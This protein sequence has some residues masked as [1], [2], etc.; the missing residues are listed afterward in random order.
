MKPFTEYMLSLQSW[1]RA[2]VR[3]ASSRWIVGP[4]LV[5]PLLFWNRLD[6]GDDDGGRENR[7]D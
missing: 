4:L 3:V 5:L 1:W 6:E 2:A 7:R